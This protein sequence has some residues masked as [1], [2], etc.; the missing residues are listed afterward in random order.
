[1][2]IMKKYQSQSRRE[3]FSR[4]GGRSLNLEAKNA[5][6]AAV[7]RATQSAP[8]SLEHDSVGSG[9]Q[10]DLMSSKIA[11]ESSGVPRRGINR[12]LVSLSKQAARVIGRVPASFNRHKNK[13]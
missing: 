10:E 7:E 13:K 12:I 3:R 8:G 4:S 11:R 5:R 1:M 9:G 6:R 2:S